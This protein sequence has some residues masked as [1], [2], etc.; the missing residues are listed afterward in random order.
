MRLA[1]ICMVNTVRKSMLLLL[2]AMLPT[3]VLAQE[4]LLDEEPADIKMYAVEIVVFRYADDGSAG[5]EIFPA[6]PPAEVAA[7]DLDVIPAVDVQ[8]R[9]RRNPD[10]VGIDPVLL[11]ADQFTMQKTVEQLELLDAYEPVLHVGWI[12]PGYPQTDTVPMQLATFGEP[13]PGLDGSFTLYLSRYLHLI[14]DLTLTAP[15]APAEYADE[16][17]AVHDFEY[18]LPPIDGPVRFRIQE[19]RI[20]RNGEVRYF[21]HPKFG[22]VAK[23]LRLDTATD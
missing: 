3:A 21:D 13:P 5:S 23:V 15:S 1:G 7:D 6:D 8:P 14:V 16:Y 17:G 12:Q 9:Q 2:A 20:T 18:A 4:E 10:F 11:R 19:D 22:V